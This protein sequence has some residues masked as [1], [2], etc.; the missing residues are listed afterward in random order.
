MQ[1][2]HRRIT[3]ECKAAGGCVYKSGGSAK[4]E[5]VVRQR[6]GAVRLMA[7]LS[8]PSNLSFTVGNEEQDNGKENSGEPGC[9]CT[10]G[11]GR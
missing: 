5:L 3:R 2:A 9:G 1:G 11:S 10:R 4:R 8:S 6:R 7:L